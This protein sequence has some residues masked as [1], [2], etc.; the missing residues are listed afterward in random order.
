MTAFDASRDFG[1]K[2]S[3]EVQDKVKGVG[4]FIVADS[5]VIAQR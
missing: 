1:W 4:T 2:A 5:I 3:P